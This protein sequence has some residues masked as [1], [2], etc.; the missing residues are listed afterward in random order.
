M[1]IPCMNS[2][3]ACDRGGSVALVEGGS[4]F[5][6][7]PG[8]PGCTTTGLD[9]SPPWPRVDGQKKP[10]GTLAASVTKTRT[11]A[12]FFIRIWPEILPPKP[13]IFKVLSID[14]HPA[15]D[16]SFGSFLPTT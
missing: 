15:A 13:E 8:A 6:G 12:V 10:R 3:S 4:V 7:L 9:D 16:R 5:V 14:F 2:T 1:I 11:Q